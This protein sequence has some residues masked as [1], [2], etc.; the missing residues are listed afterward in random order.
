MIEG[1]RN[2]KHLLAKTCIVKLCFE[3]INKAL[4]EHYRTTMER[5]EFHVNLANTMYEFYMSKEKIF[6]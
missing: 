2:D 6:L 3:I 1:T 5:N 4:I